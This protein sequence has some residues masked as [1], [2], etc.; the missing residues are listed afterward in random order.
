METTTVTPVHGVTPVYPVMYPI[1]KNKQNVCF[2]VNSGLMTTEEK[3][4][5]NYYLNMGYSVIKKNVDTYTYR[6]VF[7]NLLDYVKL[8][9]YKRDKKSETV[10][11]NSYFSKKEFELYL[12]RS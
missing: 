12:Q 2:I 8:Y 3:T 11:V 4:L 5:F 1:K 7:Q 10:D 6:F 9:I